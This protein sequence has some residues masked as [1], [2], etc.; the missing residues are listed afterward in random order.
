MN[1]YVTEIQFKTTKFCFVGLYVVIDSEF[2]H[3]F[4]KINNSTS[5]G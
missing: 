2:E 5:I 1:I 3:K 4:V